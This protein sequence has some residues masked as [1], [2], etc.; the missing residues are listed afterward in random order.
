MEDL[1]IIAPDGRQPAM[2]GSRMAIA[3]ASAV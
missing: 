3:C 2:A 1:T